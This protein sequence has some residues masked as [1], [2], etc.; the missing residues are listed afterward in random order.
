MSSDELRRR[1]EAFAAESAAQSSQCEIR[2]M[3]AERAAEDCYSAEYLGQHIGEE[4]F[5]NISGITEWGIYVELECSAE[6]FI[7]ADSLPSGFLF[8]G[9][10]TFTRRSSGTSLTIGDPMQVRVIRADV[11]SGQVDFLPV[12]C[13]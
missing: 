10:L 11:S 3:A 5:G 12:N 13:K 4:F 1:Y 8:D 6:G 7:R 2:A 9:N